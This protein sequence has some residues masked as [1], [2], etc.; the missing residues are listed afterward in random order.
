MYIHNAW[1]ML[2]YYVSVIYLIMM[3]VHHECIYIYIMCNQKCL[4]MSMSCQSNFIS[5]LICYT[6]CKLCSDQYIC[7]FSYYKSCLYILWDDVE[8][9]FERGF[10]R[11][12]Y[13]FIPHPK[14]CMPGHVRVSG[15]KFPE[16]PT[17]ATT[18]SWEF[19]GP[20]PP[21]PP[22]KFKDS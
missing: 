3:Y 9:L 22:Q 16:V 2:T 6:S 14:P 7:V 4:C 12:T 15:C 18:K 8:H 5:I 13:P 20:H 11:E 21:M 17:W 10:K 19:K 1:T